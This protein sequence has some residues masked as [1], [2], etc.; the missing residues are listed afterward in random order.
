MRLPRFASSLLLLVALLS[1][2]ARAAS[3]QAL[4]D[5]P[6]SDPHTSAFE[7]L[8]G[9]SPYWSAGPRRIFFAA[10]FDVG[11][12]Y[13][14]TEANIGWGK[15]F[16]SWGGIETSTRLTPGGITFYGGPRLTIPHLQLRMG[17]R[18]YSSTDNNYLLPRQT[19]ERVQL[20]RDVE[21]RAH[22]SSLDAE[23][24]VDAPL[25]VGTISF[26][27]SLNDIFGVDHGYFVLDDALRVIVDPP[28]VW[29]TRLAY[30]VNVGKW[31]DMGVGGAVELIGVPQRDATFVRLGPVV[32]VSLTH[33]LQA[34]GAAG[35]VVAGRDHIGL[36]GADLGQ[37]GLRYRWATGD[38]WPEFP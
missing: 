7:G 19:Y 16:Y 17:L 34:T 37:I 38:L 3:A 31:E 5:L 22:Y 11:V 29:R 10:N 26:T 18:H 33:H 4:R 24:T 28:W 15:P 36:A 20:D 13:G 27:A 9:K 25:P 23:V 32:T 2:G 1:L 12:I 8:Q 35:F 30:L 14:R 21:P 6:G